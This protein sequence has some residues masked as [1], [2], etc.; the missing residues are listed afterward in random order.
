[1]TD[2]NAIGPVTWVLDNEALE[3]L[4][5][6]IAVSEEVVCDLE[7]TG[8]DE[9]A[10]TGGEQNGGVAARVSLASFTLPVEGDAPGGREPTTWVLPLSHPDS[11]FVGTWQATLGATMQA[12]VDHDRPLVN[13][14]VKFDARWVFATTGVDVSSRIIWDT[15]ISSHLLDENES[16]RLKERAPATFGVDRWDD[17]DLTYPGASE[18][19]PLFELGDYAARDTYWTWRLAVAHRAR[20]FPVE[21][22]EGSEEVTEARLGRLA[23]WC[24]M[25]TVAS[26]TQIEQRGMLLDVDWTREHL[27]ADLERR[28]GLLKEMA[29]RYGMDP[30]TASAAAT[31]KWFKE[32]TER[33]VEA[34]ELRVASLTPNGNP[35]WSKG[36]LV[37]Q[38]REGS[39]AAKMVL[40]QRH[41]AKRAEYLSSWLGYVTPAGQIHST[42]HA[43][44]V[45]TGRLSSSDPNMQQITGTLKPAFI[46]RPGNV[47]IDLDYSQVE[48]RVAAFVSRCAPMIEAFQRGD[49]LHRLLA[50][51]IIAEDRVRRQDFRP[52]SAADVTD[53]DRQKGKSANFGLLYMMG[54]LGFREY[55]ETAYG[56]S[57]TLEEAE[58]VHAAFYEMW[59]G[60]GAWHRR[61]IRRARQTG[62][63][64]SPI[65]RVRRIPDIHDGYPGAV[66]RAERMAVNSPVQGF[67]SDLMQMAAAS[68]QGL[69]PGTTAVPGAQIVATVH[70]SIVVEAPEDRWEAVTAG[71]IERM[72]TL[73]TVLERL[74][75]ILDVPLVAEAKVGTR[76]G[77]ADVSRG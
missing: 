53:E 24:A 6:A 15:Q 12:V 57:L 62:Y 8:L 42:Y 39:V 45:V 63:V 66:E 43:G 68:I 72:T 60:I 35:Q 69:L 61:V 34:G 25:P 58:R 36:V 59:D 52:V 1:M 17:H 7:T 30:G 11:P 74:D 2:K 21:P 44:R 54:A 23:A 10:V 47:I 37:R 77:L 33:A 38:V 76:W 9:H 22:P 14:N 16:T 5:E 48:L 29:E 4:L 20:M 64:V 3:H 18:E 13:Q 31:S 49:D 28:D 73:E 46:P 40:D 19:V 32:W 67:A 75:C 50:Q 65:G 51:R 27:A 41:H 55:A 71:C 56:V 70:D 26:L